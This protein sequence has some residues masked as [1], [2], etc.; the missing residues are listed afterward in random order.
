MM[1]FEYLSNVL[2][3]YIDTSDIIQYTIGLTDY[4]KR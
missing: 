1:R 3:I 4:T 2:S